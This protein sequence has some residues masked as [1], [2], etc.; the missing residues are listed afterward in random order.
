VARLARVQSRQM[1]VVA[2]SAAYGTRSGQIGPALAQRLGVP[3]VDRVI[4]HRVAG[5]LDVS[6]DE[7][8]RNWE[9]APRSFV[10][11]MVSAFLGADM[12][13]SVGPPPDIVNAEDFRQATER[14]V[15]EQAATGEGVI[16]G[17]GCVAVLRKTPAVLRVRLTG[18]AERRLEQ[19]V[20]TSGLSESDA[21]D[22][23]NHLDRYHAEYLKQFYGVNID[24]STMYHLTIDATALDTDACVSLLVAA[25]HALGG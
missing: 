24:D 9:P 19:A 25:A 16:L 4:A 23:M 3:F 5:Q 12:V 20:K 8:V 7:A 13:A 1:T 11:R 22:T 17:R 10:E 18:P 15:L 21:R 14:A 2:I 6:V